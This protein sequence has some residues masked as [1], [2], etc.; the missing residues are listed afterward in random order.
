MPL[1]QPI[2]PDCRALLQKHTRLPINL[3]QPHKEPT[4]F[5]SNIVGSVFPDT[6]NYVDKLAI[7]NIIHLPMGFSSTTA[8]NV[9]LHNPDMYLGATNFWN[10]VCP[11]RLIIGRHIR[12][13]P[14]ELITQAC[15]LKMDIEHFKLT[16]KLLRNTIPF[17][18]SLVH[19]RH[20]IRQVETYLVLSGRTVIYNLYPRDTRRTAMFEYIRAFLEAMEADWVGTPLMKMARLD[21]LSE[22]K[23][24]IELFDITNMTHSYYPC[25]TTWER[26]IKD[27]CHPSY[28]DGAII[29]VPM[30]NQPSDY[31]ANHLLEWKTMT[32]IGPLLSDDI[33]VFTMIATGHYNDRRASTDIAKLAPGFLRYKETRPLS[34]NFIFRFG[35][36]NLN[37]TIKALHYEDAGAVVPGDMVWPP[38]T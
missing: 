21:F 24:D 8:L 29:V 3:P 18:K 6:D 16:I 25:F 26:L 19:E 33:E 23:G 10:S 27:E 2:G 38:P 13:V 35:G 9:L 36:S 31:Q 20:Y 12:T 11:N 22:A 30:R 5:T 4:W 14:N 28:S 34:D 15:S 32:E 37:K 1:F 7:C 17:D